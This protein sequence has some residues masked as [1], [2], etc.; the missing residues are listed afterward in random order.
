MAA[1]SNNKSL[2]LLTSSVL[3][4][5]PSNSGQDGNGNYY[6]TTDANGNFTIT[7]DYSCAAGQQVY[8]YALGGTQG[9]IANPAAG[10]LAAL[11][12]CPGTAGTTNDSFSSG[13]FLVV[14]EVST[15]ATAYAFAGF[16]TDAT[17]V[18]SSG[19][20]L[21]QT[22]VANAFAN[23]ANLETLGT[24]VALATT[25]AGN[26]TVPQTTINT[27]ANILASCVN[28]TGATSSPCVTILA[29]AKSAGAS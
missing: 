2:S 21:A 29:F 16:A 26:G 5:N 23:A 1:S 18:S 20:A 3:T 15:V 10:L 9:G 27:V 12:N 14:N 13:L 4:N 25:P 6:V 17:H 22:G 7:G 8:L 11:G 28:T 19:T 24:G